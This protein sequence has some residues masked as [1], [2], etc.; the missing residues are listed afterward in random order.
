MSKA[1]LTLGIDASGLSKHLKGAN[2]AKPFRT[3]YIFKKIIVPLEIN[4]F[5]NF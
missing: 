1:A 5:S 3:K 2:A 4:N